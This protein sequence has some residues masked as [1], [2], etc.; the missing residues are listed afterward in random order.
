MFSL[1][2][3]RELEAQVFCEDC[4]ERRVGTVMC[5]VAEAS[6]VVADNGCVIG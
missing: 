2:D 1:L 4:I 3:D 5:I 6:T